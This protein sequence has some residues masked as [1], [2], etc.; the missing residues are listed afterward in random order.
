ML[1]ISSKGDFVNINSVL[2]S[3]HMSDILLGDNALVG[4]AFLDAGLVLFGVSLL[5]F[6]AM[7]TL[8]ILLKRNPSLALVLAGLVKIQLLLLLGIVV[9]DLWGGRPSA[10]I[11]GL[12]DFSSSLA[13]HRYLIIQLPFLLLSASATTLFVYGEKIVERHAKHYFVASVISIW[14]SFAIILLIGFES[15]V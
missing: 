14:L 2:Y 15:M 13:E 11:A 10:T 6:G 4:F 12:S 7:L 1:M 9:L 8:S 5:L 3:T